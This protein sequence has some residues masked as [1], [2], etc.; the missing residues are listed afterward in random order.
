MKKFQVIYID[1]EGSKR[2][3]KVM[4][5]NNTHAAAIFRKVVSKNNKIVNIMEVGKNNYFFGFKVAIAVA[6]FVALIVVLGVTCCDWREPTPT[7]YEMYIV[8]EGDSLWKIATMSD[9]YNNF[10]TT[11]IV[12][13]IQEYSNCT[14]VIYP[15]QVVYVPM[16]SK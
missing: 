6:V 8:K 12:D 1:N 15:G 14:S 3:F 4:A 7:D 16:Y 10:D 13:H 2:V 11:Y 5:K 9:G